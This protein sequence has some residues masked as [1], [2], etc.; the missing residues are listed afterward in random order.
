MNPGRTSKFIGAGQYGVVFHCHYN[1]R[2]AAIKKFKL[3]DKKDQTEIIEHEID[4]LRHLQYRHIIQ[5]YGVIRQ[6]NEISLI[7]DFAEGGSLNDAIQDLRV[8][9]W[10]VKER[11]A[12]EIA[13]GLAYIH[14]EDIIHRDLK[15]DNVLLTGLME[16]KLCDFGLAVVKK[17]S[18]S[19]ST[20]VMRG[21]VRWLAPELLRAA[22]P[23]YTSKSDIYALGM[24]MWEMAAMCT[25]PFKTIDN[26]F[27]VAKAVHGG[28]R[29]KL[30]DNTPPD[31]WCWVELCW[32]QDPANRPQAHEVI[33]AKVLANGA[34][35]RRQPTN[36]V[37]S[38][39]NVSLK[40][41]LAMT[42]VA[43][44][45]LPVPG[46]SPKTFPSVPSPSE[47]LGVMHCVGDMDAA[48]LSAEQTDD[49]AT[50]LHKEASIQQK[51]DLQTSLDITTR[52]SPATETDFGPAPLFP[53]TLRYEL[54]ALKSSLT[55]VMKI[56]FTKQSNAGAVDI[57]QA[58]DR[59]NSTA[60]NTLGSMYLN[61]QVVEQGDVEAVK[62]F[63][64]AA[65]QGNPDGQN[66]LGVMYENGRGVEQS[67]VEAVKWYTKAAGQ[68][69]RS[70]KSNLGR[71]YNDGRGVEQSDV[72]TSK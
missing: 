7:T 48:G 8:A 4:L 19:H 43:T 35:S 10:R 40:L 13:N 2:R 26:N 17:S 38:S 24:V 31:Y 42:P 57:R 70:G 39:E 33:L 62:W 55:R 16:V 25:L 21:T 34:S 22:K 56:S 11:I 61:G 15:S 32:R 1:A 20:E 3:Q 65:N 60:Q 23:S 59:G 36:A 50:R 30:P 53:K 28:E 71:I 18:G 72:K 68:G 45:N 47:E 54:P 41:S 27:V 52:G 37:A 14:H 58:A 63:T 44:V 66:N 6:D 46:T 29:E 5:F 12:Q 67:D 51:Y 69:S 9:D 49:E 64:K